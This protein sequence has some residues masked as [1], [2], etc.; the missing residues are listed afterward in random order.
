MTTPSVSAWQWHSHS[1]SKS[2]SK[3]KPTNKWPADVLTV[4]A[5]FAIAPTHVFSATIQNEPPAEKVEKITVTGTRLKT[6]NQ[7]SASPITTLDSAAIAYSGKTSIQEIVM[8]LGALAGSQGND[9]VSN[10]ENYLNLR[11]LG[12]NRTLT[13]VD[14]QRFVSGTDNGVSGVDTSAIPLAMIDRVEV[15]TGGASAIYGADA[16]TGVVNFILKD[17]FE[18]L[19]FDGRYGDAF[20]GDFSEQLYA[21]TAGNNF[22]DERG[23]ITASYT[24]GRQPVVLATARAQAST[25]IYENINNPNGDTPRFVLATGVN[26][27]FFS[28]G[29]SVIDPFGVFSSS[30]N[31]DGSPFEH[32][33]NVGG[34][35]GTSEIGGDGAPNYILF[36]NGIRPAN[37]RHIVTFKARFDVTDAFKPYIDIHY[38]DVS[39][40]TLTQQSLSVGNQLARDNAF[41]PSSVLAAAGAQDPIYFNRWD[42]DSGYSDLTADK[43]T[44]RILLGA[45]GEF[46]EYL[47]YDLTA[48][49]GQSKRTGRVRNNRLYDRY[50]AAIDAVDDG[51]GHIVCRSNLDPASFQNLSGDF[52]ATSFDSSLGGVTFTPGQNSGCLPFNP[53]IRDSSVNQAAIDW[54]WQPTS[55]RQKTTQTVISGYLA[56]DT[57]TFM[58]LPGGA[59]NVIVGAEYREEEMATRFDQ[60]TSGDNSLAYFSGNDLAGEFDVTE[61]FAEVSLPLFKNAGSLMHSL[62]LDAAY[63]ASD[64]STIG[65]TQTWKLGTIW[66]PIE[67]LSVRGTVSSAVRAPNIAELFT[68]QISITTSLADDPCHIDNINLGSPTRAA[69]CAIGLSALGIEPATFKPLLGT[70]FPGLRGGSPDLK[71]EVAKT[72]TVGFI[73]Q[74]TAID[75]LMLSVDHFDITLTD[76][77]ITPRQN[78]IFNACYDSATLDNP[79]CAL[80]GRDSTTGLANYVELQAL[81]VARVET[82]GVELAANYRFV[83]SH[84]SA[85]KLALN[86]TYLDELKLQKS[87]LPVLTDDKGLFNTDTGGSS[88]E[89]VSNLNINWQYD[90][91]DANYRF[92]YHSST[93]RPGLVNEQRAT[94]NEITDS[95]TV[96]AFI[97]HDVQLG[98]FY[99]NSTRI[100]VGIRNLTNEYPDK[101]QASLAG[102]SGRQ[103]YAGRRFYLGLS[104]QLDEFLGD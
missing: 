80:I 54:I 94:A 97:N 42:L 101:A 27:S 65:D 33:T 102:S 46:S 51:T 66:Q 92:N 25:D 22:A 49:I 1:H 60:L 13:L 75:G 82:S 19:A 85:F 84:G 18:G 58:T 37:E 43:R 83:T 50:A 62:I 79:F 39:T 36:T 11:N 76:A 74:P 53:L 87:E 68:P 93:L 21:I 23:N 34:F 70:V 10:G 4:F 28:N 3:S 47:R 15:F 95:P 88:P 55:N 8:E 56:G 2:P 7:Q 64:Y 6:A 89:W 67:N 41:L 57:A 38:S 16:V 73:W 86:A 69:N 96:K 30:F 9:E 29:G 59:V 14:G 72:K 78:A 98:Y 24:Y 12:S 90:N 20:E 63:R 103:S 99:N 61:A 31:G 5:V 104:W 48:N 26:E 35:G 91:W 45:K 40:Q 100:T 71:E 44:Y 81:N 17:N 32:G 77:V 52:L